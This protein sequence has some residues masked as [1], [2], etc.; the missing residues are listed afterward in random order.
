MNRPLHR[1][2]ALMAIIAQSSL[3]F[4][5]LWIVWVGFGHQAAGAFALGGMICV[6]PN[7]CMYRMVFAH[8]GASQ[9]KRIIQAFYL[10]EAVKLLLTA[11]GFAGAFLI[12]GVMPLWLFLGFITAQVGFG[13]VSIFG[14]CVR[15]VAR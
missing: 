3:V 5:L 10:G 2:D 14:V 13:L 11:L 15:K 8:F 9:T 6:I 4:V 1:N 12:P 7:L